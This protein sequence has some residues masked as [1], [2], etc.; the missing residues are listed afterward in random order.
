MSS[1]LTIAIPTYNR[2]S[3]LE[4]SLS[5]LRNEISA[6]NEDI[7]LIVSDNCST[8]NTEVVTKN[9]IDSGLKI[10]Y[11]KN[12]RNLGMDGNFLQCLKSAHGKYVWILGDDDYILDGKLS[13]IIDAI[14][15]DVDFGLI[16]LNQAGV[17]T[18]DRQI[19]QDHELFLESVGFWITFISANIINRKLV[20]KVN[21]DKY[22]GTNLILVPFY[23]AAACNAKN[24]LL[25][26]DKIIDGGKDFK[27]NGGYNLFKVFVHYFISILQCKD[28]GY[29]LSS[30]LLLIEKRNLLLNFLWYF[31][32]RFLYKKEKSNFDTSSAWHYLTRYYWSSPYYYRLIL[33]LYIKQITKVIKK[34]AKKIL[35]REQKA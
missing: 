27:N 23:L 7:E 21:C 31:I 10:Q 34:R 5:I 18:S 35:R 16:H 2:A 14:K 29:E 20:E 8:D 30:K 9:Y 24:N 32:E 13:V 12:D 22:Y 25:V 11:I 6:I 17:K 1:L 26:N 4:N 3:F 15:N 28:M 33:S 19:F